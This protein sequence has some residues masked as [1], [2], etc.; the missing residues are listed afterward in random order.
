MFLKVARRTVAP[1]MVNAGATDAVQPREKAAPAKEKKRKGVK[2]DDDAGDGCE[3]DKR[4]K[5]PKKKKE[6]EVTGEGSHDQ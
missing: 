2:N 4:F 6:G 1:D 5:T 3:D